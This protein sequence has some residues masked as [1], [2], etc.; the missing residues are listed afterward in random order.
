MTTE[1]RP[2]P[3]DALRQLRRRGAALKD[4]MHQRASEY[5]TGTDEAG[6]V[7][8]T[9][10][11]RRWLTGLYMQEG[12]LELEAAT[13]ERRVNVALRN[14]QAAAMAAGGDQQE[15]LTN[16]WPALPVGSRRG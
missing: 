7:E 10:N 16:G 3:E 6:S 15:R 5:F 9:V 2:Q 4:R 1:K 12:L 14:A 11:G 13:V 8:V